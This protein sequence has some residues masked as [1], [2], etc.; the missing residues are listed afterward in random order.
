MRASRS[1]GS[2]RPRWSGIGST[3]KQ[4]SAGLFLMTLCEHIL[5]Y[6][7]ETT[8]RPAPSAPQRFGRSATASRAAVTIV[9]EFFAASL[10]FFFLFKFH[11]LISVGRDN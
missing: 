10:C 4:A 2:G 6:P 3:S 7:A 1:A 9:R 11:M 8:T 5:T